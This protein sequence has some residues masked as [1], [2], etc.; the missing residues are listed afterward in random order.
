MDLYVTFSN[1]PRVRCGGERAM[2]SV[3]KKKFSDL[4]NRRQTILHLLDAIPPAHLTHKAGPDRWSVVEVIQ[5]LVIVEQQIMKQAES[6]PTPT[7]AGTEPQP[8]SR[9][10]LEMVLEILETDVAVDVPAAS[11]APDGRISLA[12]LLDQWAETRLRLERFLRKM[13]ADRYEELLFSHPIAGPLS[14]VDMLDLADVHLGY[15]LR[16]IQR[17]GETFDELT[18]VD[19]KKEQANERRIK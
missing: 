2:D 18:N 15:H 10:R 13:P 5:H 6:T 19:A 11:M 7:P 9:E 12:T 1:G 14:V 16:Q 8:Y 17:L 3:I 4:E